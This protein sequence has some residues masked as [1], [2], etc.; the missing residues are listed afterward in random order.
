MA[1]RIATIM[2]VVFILAGIVGFISND[3]LGFHLTAFHNAGVH[4]VSGAISLYFG[5]KGTLAGARLFCLIFGVVYAL[6]GVVGFVAGH[7][8]TPSPGVPGPADPRLFKAIP[9]MLEL[10]TSDHILHILLGLVFVAGGLL[11]RAD[12][13]RAVD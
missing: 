13:N 12:L 2:G 5:L 1:K 7:Q 11:T 6:I 3:L 4:I 9:G 8:D 10:G